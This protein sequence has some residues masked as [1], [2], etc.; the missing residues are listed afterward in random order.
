MAIQ[1]ILQAMCT[2]QARVPLHLTLSALQEAIPGACG[3]VS[4]SR[5]CVHFYSV[6]P[7]EEGRGEAGQRHPAPTGR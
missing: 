7:G 3:S 4:A 6:S 1:G 2:H 5:L